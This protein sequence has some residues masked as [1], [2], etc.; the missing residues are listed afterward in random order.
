MNEI[1]LY[2]LLSL[3]GIGIISAVILYLI[4]TKFK[5]I[6]DPRIDDLEEVLPGANCGGCSYPGCRN[7]A[8]EIVKAGNLDGFNCPVGGNE[9]MTDVGKI[10]GLEA[11]DVDPMVAVIRCAGSREHAPQK[12][13]YE[14]AKSCFVVNALY[15]GE[16]DCPYGC[17]GLGDCVDACTFDAMYMDE[18]TGLPV[19]IED[20]CTACNACVKACP[21]DIIEL[22]SVGKKGRRIFVSCINEEKGG[23]AK[24]YCSVACTGCTKCFK[25]CKFDAIVMENNLAYIIDEKC[26]LCRL[27]PPECATN[28]IWEVGFP[29]KKPKK[30]VEDIK[31]E[32]TAEVT[33]DKVPEKKEIEDK[34]IKEAD[35]KEDNKEI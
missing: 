14:G 26:R 23:I 19:V 28:S 29:P 10:M 18:K 21:R 12:T 20:K 16:N 2:A 31:K 30:V 27:C 15:T 3:G 25:V 4:A 22:R 1:V 8:E 11:E 17:S 6:E 35:T 34:D 7:F 13:I 9:V 32:V 24:K 5:V 33:Q